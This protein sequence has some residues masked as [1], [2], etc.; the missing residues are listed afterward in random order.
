[1]T[2]LYPLVPLETVYEFA[3]LILVSV[4]G[5][6]AVWY[7]IFAY[8]PHGRY[9]MNRYTGIAEEQILITSPYPG[10]GLI[11]WNPVGVAVNKQYILEMWGQKKDVDMET[12]FRRREAPG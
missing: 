8:S 10:A 9:R 11:I 2:E 1:M 7:R 6:L 5:L 4:I 3:L 12:N